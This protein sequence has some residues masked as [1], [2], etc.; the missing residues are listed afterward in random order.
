MITRELTAYVVD[1]A[2]D[3]LTG[4]LAVELV[5]PTPADA[6]AM[7]VGRVVYALTAGELPDNTT[8]VSGRYEF[9]IRDSDGNNLRN[10]KANVSD[11]VA[12]AQ[13][14]QDLYMSAVAVPDPTANQ[15]FEGDDANLLD[16]GDGD[17]DDVWT[18]GPEGLASWQ[19]RAGAGLGDMNG[20]ASSEDANIA[21]FSGTTGKQL[22]DSGKTIAELKNE[23][24][25][26]ITNGAPVALD[27]LIELAAALGNDA[28]YAATITTALGTKASTAALTTEATSRINGD[29]ARLPLAGGTLTGP[30][31]LAAAPA[32]DLQAATK[33]YVDDAIAAISGAADAGQVYLMMRVFG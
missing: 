18:R 23:V 12:T 8:I 24:V 5:A 15:V 6:E 32:A 26:Q 1:N 4:T 33:K 31:V 2:G 19:S 3:P 16:F 13:S 9:T 30:L 29:N 7:A 17:E 14:L 21:L 25:A 10:W 11:A 27:T 22:A 20:P 28:N